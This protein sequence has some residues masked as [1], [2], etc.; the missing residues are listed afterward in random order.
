MLREVLDFR[1]QLPQPQ[2]KMVELG[3]VLSRIFSMEM[4]N[5][6]GHE[7]F[8]PGLIQ[9][10]LATLQKDILQLM[11]GIAFWDDNHIVERSHN[12]DSWLKYAF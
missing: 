4:L 12:D 2:R 9:S 10:G 1:L 11:G 3:R 5:D 6:L 7:G 8:N